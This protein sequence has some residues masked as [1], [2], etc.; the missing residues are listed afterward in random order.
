MLRRQRWLILGTAVIVAVA[1]GVFASIQ[2]PVYTATTTVLLRP[3]DPTE[4]LGTPDA[5]LDPTDLA[6]YVAGQAIIVR[7]LPVAQAAAKRLPKDQQPKAED[8]RDLLDDIA[9]QQ[10]DLSNVIGISAH[11]SSAAR[12]RNLADAFA[13]AYIT[14]RKNFDVSRLQDAVAAVQTKLA[15]VQ[16]TIDTLTRAGAGAPGATAAQ[17]AALNAA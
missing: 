10:S 1:A 11:G 13:E 2:T 16:A 15:S 17:Q 7:S 3:N 4:S 5:Q 14:S 8:V 6:R 12:A 9:V